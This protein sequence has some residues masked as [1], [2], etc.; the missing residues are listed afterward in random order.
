MSFNL[1]RENN[2][3][4][5]NRADGDINTIGSVGLIYKNMSVFCLL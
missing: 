5:I 4:R 2:F 3:R 1:S